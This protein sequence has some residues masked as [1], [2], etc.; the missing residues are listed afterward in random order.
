MR[1]STLFNNGLMR[2]MAVAAL[3]ATGLAASAQTFVHEGLIYK[4]NKGKLELQAPGTKPTAGETVAEYTGDYVIPTAIE[5]NGKSYP[6]STLKSAFKNTGVHS[7]EISD[8]AAIQIARGC[9]QN[10]TNLV[11]AKLNSDLPKF[12][13]DIFNGCTSL[14]SINIPASVTDVTSNAFKGCTALTTITID[15]SSEALALGREAFGEV[16]AV[17]HL[18]MNRPIATTKYTE[19]DAKPFRGATALKKVEIGG[20]CTALTDVY[21]ENCTALSDVTIT[22]D[23]TSFGSRVFANTAI[24][25][26]TMPAKVTAVSGSMF[27]NTK[28]LTKVVLNEGITS[29]SS[30]AFS[31]TSLK[32]INFPSTL[33]S[34]GQM[35]FSKAN[36]TGEVVLPEGL[37]SID[38]QA[39]ANNANITAITLPATLTSLGDGAFVGCSS[40][41][42]FVVA[43]DNA[44]FAASADGSYITTKDGSTVM[45][46]APAAAATE[47]KGNFTAVAPYAFYG[48]KNLTSIDLPACTNWGDYALRGSGI[49]SLKVAGT[50]GRYLAADCA[51]LEALTV[52]CAEVPMG[53]AYNCAALSDVQLLRPLT[54]VRQDAFNGCTKVEKLDLGKILAILET[55]CFANSGLKEITVASYYPAAMAEGVFTEA[56]NITVTVPNS[57]VE[58]YKVAAGW[59]YLTIQGDENLAIGGESLGMPAGLYYAGDDDNL[60][61][62]YQKGGDDTYEIGMK[63]TFQLVEFSNR[64]YGASAGNKFWYEGAA[65]AVNGDGKLFYISKVGD[66]LFQAVVLDNTGG[67]AY[68]DPTGLYIYG[69]TLYVN[70]R[71]VCVRKISAD[72]IAL[73]INYPSWMENNWMP[74]Y[75]GTWTYG[76]I[77]NGFAITQ[78]QDA[79]GNPEP[80]YWVGMKYNGCGLFSFKQGNIGTS[81]SEVGSPNGAVEYL[82]GL[83]MIATAFNIDTKHGDLY[84]Y[85]ETAGTENSLIK[86]GL[87]RIKLEDLE[88]NPT[89]SAADFF[90]VLGAQLID[91][92]PVKY[93]GNATNEHVG[94]SQLAID[95]NGEYM[96]W[97][98]RAPDQAEADENEAQDFAAQSAGKYWWADKYDATNPLHHSGIKRIKLGEE[99]PTVEMVAPDVTGYGI[100]ALNYEGSTKPA[101]GVTA[102]VVETENLVT[103]NGGNVTV[104]QDAAVV[105]YNAAGIMVDF[106][107]LTAGATY[108]TA[109]LAAGLYLVEA[110]TAAGT[111]VVKVV[112]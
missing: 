32:D 31:G 6:V 95:A 36:L 27:E 92:S 21:F 2:S 78:D 63:H 74:F 18:I 40:L 84:M 45:A 91:G 22:S 86:G 42:K 87:Y 93:E 35:A 112:K 30:M 79:E 59:K 76:C 4:V 69:S 13:G 3:V 102:P 75:G 88:Q 1:I 62:L 15:E 46:Y 103:V 24:A 68:K 51:A 55:D 83:G 111:Q 94:I 41:A 25:E 9:F 28:A 47:F 105:V 106:A 56:S 12:L 50:V 73:P 82:T 89:P 65:S 107:N 90:E 8:G 5:Y 11:S 60:H 44:A 71:N 17:E 20:T 38:A 14:T 110:R 96:Y 81:S 109:N 34:I 16:P 33:T 108:S 64:I 101:D 100:V 57:L 43:A 26:F 23:F 77:K 10:C 61:C 58:A 97:C 72:A 104:A 70:D 98:Y 99:N 48:A 29:I 85:I 7:V 37:K 67:N 49:K 80:R 66:E 19:Q 54:I 53:I 52:D 39:F